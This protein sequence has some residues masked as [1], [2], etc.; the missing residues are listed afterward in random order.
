MPFYVAPEQQMK[1]RAD[2]ARKG[3]ARG[4]SV[5]VLHYADGI[6]F[7]AENRSQALHKVSEI[8]DRIGFAAVGRYNEFENLRIAGIR[9]AD[10]RGYSYDRS[11]V[12]GRAL[13]NAYAQLLGTIFS[14]GAEKPY[15]VEL[16]VAELGVTPETDQIYRLTYDGSVQDEEGFAV[17]G[18]SA[19]A[20]TEFV[21]QEYEPGLGLADAIRLAVR[22]LGSESGEQP[23]ELGVE[24]LEAAILDRTR[25]QPRKFRRLSGAR[26]AELLAAPTTA[27]L[28][29]NATE[30]AA[31]TADRETGNGDD[32]P[33]A[34][35]S[36]E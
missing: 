21:R 31:E 17:M 34:E 13:A 19:D 6:L 14:S 5:V 28:P 35:S 22:A 27:D 24:S 12:T 32:G 3:I 10:F 23:R 4:R 8:Y 25:I 29:D 15:E 2:Y 1:D 11:D 18:G 16:I 36:P 26:L 7:V 9:H 20:I 33:A 30:A